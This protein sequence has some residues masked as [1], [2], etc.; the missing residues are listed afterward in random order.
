MHRRNAGVSRWVFVA[1]LVTLLAS[2]NTW[3][4]VKWDL[5]TG[6]PESSFHVKNLREFAKDVGSRTN[7]QV[8]ITIHPGGALVKAIEVRQAVI[9]GKVAAGEIFGPSLAPVHPV[10]GLDAIPFLATNYPSARRLWN[11]SRPLA[12]KKVLDKGFALLYSVPWPPQGMFSSK[13][14]RIAQ[15]LLGMNMR[16]NS[17]SVKKL[18]EAL[19]AQPV[20]VETPDLV[21]AVKSD[22]VSLVFTSAAQGVDTKMWE[23]LPWFYRTNAWLPRN[24]VIINKKA[25]DALVP[26]HRDAVI[27]AAGA[28]EERGWLMSEQNAAETLKALKDNGAKM[29]VIDGS[30][31]ARLDKAGTTLSGDAL[32][33]ADPELLQVLSTFISEK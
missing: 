23:K 10:F 1:G 31:R 12:E 26:E 29:G 4:Q 8:I 6:Y 11:L 9:D 28:A 27:R 22:K 5:A 3:A 14:I 24:V 20:L 32:R 30:V 25:L 18:A 16:E 2:A 7:D 19:G 13:E 17:P 33:R 21:S 15:D